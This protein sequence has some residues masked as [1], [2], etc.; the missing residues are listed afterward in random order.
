MICGYWPIESICT[1]Y[2]EFR[3]RALNVTGAQYNVTIGLSD[4]SFPGV[5][6]LLLRL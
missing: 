5:K 6:D 2:F 1:E 3:A 4:I